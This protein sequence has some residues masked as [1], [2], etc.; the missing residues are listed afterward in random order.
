[1]NKCTTEGE[2]RLIGSNTTCLLAGRVEL[3]YALEWRAVCHSMWGRADAMVVCQ[4]FGFPQE[5]RTL[6]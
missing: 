4:Q 2:I 1:M 5:G 3:C 6:I